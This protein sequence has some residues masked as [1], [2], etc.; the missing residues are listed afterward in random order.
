M[1]QKVICLFLII[2]CSAFI[3]LTIWFGKS[4]KQSDTYKNPDVS[5]QSISTQ[6]KE[7][8]KERRI[9]NAEKIMVKDEKAERTLYWENLDL[10]NMGVCGDFLNSGS[11]FTSYYSQ[12]ADGHYYYLRHIDCILG[13]PYRGQQYVYVIYQDEGEI[14]GKF[15]VVRGDME[16]FLK[17]KND[18]F[19]FYDYGD[20][21]L[22]RVNTEKEFDR[23]SSK[24]PWNG[25]IP[26]FL[27]SPFWLYDNY[28][29]YYPGYSIDEKT[30]IKDRN[31]REDVTEM[32][33]APLNNL[34]DITEVKIPGKIIQHGLDLD[35]IF[36]DGKIIYG[37]EKGGEINLY[38]YDM[39]TNT[40]LKFFSFQQK[41]RRIKDRVKIQFDKDYIYCGEYLIPFSGGEIQ[42]I[43]NK[44][45]KIDYSYN[46]KYIYY[47]DK[48][49]YVHQIDKKTKKN[50]IISRIKAMK[51]DA[52][53]QS[54]YVQRYDRDLFEDTVIPYKQLE[55]HD[56]EY[57]EW[58]WYS[59]AIYKMDLDGKNP[60]MIV[61]EVTEVE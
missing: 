27:C 6:S 48:N 26:S 39:E 8:E 25:E 3:F 45:K 54:V 34:T 60:H 17:Y 24:N 44:N 28:I 22:C 9:K 50:K 15:R 36:V 58:D 49:F 13:E 42:I 21:Q 11:P 31:E 35:L 4:E 57:G 43:E 7:D 59:C 16:V 41:K 61:D 46:E 51:V 10:N 14:V 29:Y 53:D 23:I 40:E 20:N 30:G 19:V 18:Y 52:T 1:K 2:I 47:I 38:S 37:E 56:W 32:V 55:D 5:S 33:K 12:V